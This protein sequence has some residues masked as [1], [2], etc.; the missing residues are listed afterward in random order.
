MFFPKLL[1]KIIQKKFTS[2]LCFFNLLN[3][4]RLST[5]KSTIQEWVFF[6]MKAGLKKN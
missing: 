6:N 3:I 1:K 4:S 5:N 2:L